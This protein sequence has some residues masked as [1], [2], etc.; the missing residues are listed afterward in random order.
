MTNQK[1]AKF[2]P[3]KFLHIYRVLHEYQTNRLEDISQARAQQ[4]AAGVATID[5]TLQLI[6]IACGSCEF[7]ASRSQSKSPSA[8]GLSHIDWYSWQPSLS[9]PNC[10][11]AGPCG[12]QDAVGAL[13]LKAIRPCLERV[14][15][16][17]TTIALNH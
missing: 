11:H 12:F 1:F 9:S 6:S 3:S 4:L 10:F 13:I 14:W 7:L 16:Q 8:K 17:Q 15:L 5:H 2:S